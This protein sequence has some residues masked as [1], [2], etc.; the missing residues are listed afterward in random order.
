MGGCKS[1]KVCPPSTSHVLTLS[2]LTEIQGRRRSGETLGHVAESFGITVVE[3]ESQL[4]ANG[5]IELVKRKRA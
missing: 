5:F 3:P 1:F 2:E 4:K